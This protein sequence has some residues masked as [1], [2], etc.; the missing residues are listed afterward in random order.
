MRTTRKKTRY[1]PSFRQDAVG[2]VKRSDRP[3]GE[4]ATSLGV[5]KATLYFWWRESMGKNKK[6]GKAAAATR[7]VV[8]SAAESETSE[9]KVTRLQAENEV[10]RKRVVSLEE[11]K[12]ILKKFAAFS[13]KEKT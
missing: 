11:D 1:E 3:L 13:V 9:E 7:S 10:L 12:D 5:P 2:L 6:K 8:G 4:I